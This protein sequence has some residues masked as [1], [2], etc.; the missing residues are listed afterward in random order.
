MDRKWGSPHFFYTVKHALFFS[1][2]LFSSLILCKAEVEWNNVIRINT[3]EYDYGV[4]TSESDAPSAEFKITNITAD[5]ISILSVY[6]SCRCFKIDWDNSPISPNT[7]KTIKVQYL[8]SGDY[9]PFHKTVGVR[10][11]CSQ[12]TL[13]LSLSGHEE[14]TKEELKKRFR[15]RRKGIGFLKSSFNLGFVPTSTEYK[16]FFHFCNSTKM[17]KSIVFNSHNDSLLFFVEPNPI[18]P[19][20]IAKVIYH[21]SSPSEAQSV[22]QPI[23]I[24]IKSASRPWLIRKTKYFFDAKIIPRHNYSSSIPSS[25]TVYNLGLIKSKNKCL[26]KVTKIGTDPLTIVN[27]E[28]VQDKNIDVVSKFPIH[29]ESEEQYESIYFEIHPSI[30]FRQNRTSEILLYSDSSQYPVYS[31]MIQYKTRVLNSFLYSLKSWRQRKK[32]IAFYFKYSNDMPQ[33]PMT[34]K[35]YLQ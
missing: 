9:I 16:S 26:I 4:I 3:F 28:T 33:I 21:Y 34:N 32:D 20:S 24:I 12:E 23:D 22:H 31:I 30:S 7:S 27:I 29:V 17:E 6:Q 35:L 14:L 15:Y 13:V 19:Y 5:P 1:F 18:P 2:S 10:L 25:K 11:S 8:L